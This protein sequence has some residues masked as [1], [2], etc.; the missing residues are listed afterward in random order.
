MEEDLQSSETHHGTKRCLV[1]LGGE[2]LDLQQ[3]GYRSLFM[4]LVCLRGTELP[5]HLQKPDWLPTQAI[6]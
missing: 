1:A 3:H 6:S 2:G 4:G 5:N